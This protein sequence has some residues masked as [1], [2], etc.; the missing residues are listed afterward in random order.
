L[1]APGRYRLAVGVCVHDAQQRYYENIAT[2]EVKSGTSNN[3][4]L[5][6]DGAPAL[7]E[8]PHAWE[9]EHLYPQES[10]PV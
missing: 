2:I 9:A 7:V 1:L 8:L 6:S 10:I 3:R 5:E 4:L